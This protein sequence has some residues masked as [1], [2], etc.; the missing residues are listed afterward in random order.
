MATITHSTGTITPEAVNGY[1]ASREARTVV[2]P[3]LN[4]SNPD[5]TFRA[6]GLRKGTLTC[7]FAVE[8]DALAA[9]GVFSTPQV[10]TL[11]DPDV[12]TVGML[13]VAADGDLTI[14]LDDKT[15]VVWLVQVPFQEVSP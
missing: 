11:T 9:F 5:I 7:V 12:P 15:S 3:I 8:A 14:T 4:R 2:H 10:L 13:F 1:S 6:P